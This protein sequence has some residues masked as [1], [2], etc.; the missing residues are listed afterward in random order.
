MDSLTMVLITQAD[1]GKYYACQEV[2]SF[3]RGRIL[4]Y[5]A[6]RARRAR[7][8]CR[9]WAARRSIAHL[10]VRRASYG[11]K[12]Q[13]NGLVVRMGVFSDIRRPP[14]SGGVRCLGLQKPMAEAY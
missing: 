3:G 7:G 4:V 2:W 8:A 1:R 11:H 13:N 12:A 6:L 9:A 5:V 10:E 14:G